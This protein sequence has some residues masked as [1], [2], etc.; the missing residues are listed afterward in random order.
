MAKGL[1]VVA[2][3]TGGMRD[4]IHTGINGFLEKVGDV[5]GFSARILDL[6][7]KPEVVTHISGIAAQDA[8]AYSWKKCASETVKFYESLISLKNS[9]TNGK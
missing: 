2:S 3:D 7:A 4:Y 9:Q 1:C 8:K 5:G 6:L